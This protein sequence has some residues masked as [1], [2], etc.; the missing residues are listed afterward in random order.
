MAVHEVAAEIGAAAEVEDVLAQLGSES[1]CGQS[2]PTDALSS[3]EK[4]KVVPVD[5]EGVA[6]DALLAKVHAL[7]CYRSNS[8]R[9]ARMN[10]LKAKVLEGSQKVTP[11]EKARTREERQAGWEVR[12]SIRAAS[13]SFCGGAVSIPR[14]L[15]WC[16]FSPLPLFGASSTSLCSN[17]CTTCDSAYIIDE[18]KHL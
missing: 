11:S 16:C 5:A 3:P 7:K 4:A 2:C 6:V 17:I 14:S 1:N 15:G 8:A 10:A 18:R 13:A 9:H 12:C